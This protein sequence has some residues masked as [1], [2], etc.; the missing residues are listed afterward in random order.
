M[1]HAR[2]CQQHCTLYIRHR[3]QDMNERLRGW[4]VRF[5]TR[6]DVFWEIDLHTKAFYCNCLCTIPFK[7]DTGTRDEERV[8]KPP[9]WDLRSLLGKVA[10]WIATVNLHHLQDIQHHEIHYSLFCANLHML[11]LEYMSFTLYR[12]YKHVQTDHTYTKRLRYQLHTS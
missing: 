2:T 4:A 3:R 12:V 5:R 9:R 10:K 11:Q 6:H 8:G 1:R 7:A